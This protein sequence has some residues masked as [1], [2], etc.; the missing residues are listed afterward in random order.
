MEFT[1]RLQNLPEI[2]INS[3]MACLHFD[4]DDDQNARKPDDCQ[5]LL[6]KMEM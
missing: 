5:D 2:L 1:D 3:N 6:Q 4:D